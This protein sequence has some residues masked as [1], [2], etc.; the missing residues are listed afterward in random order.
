MSGHITPPEHDDISRRHFGVLTALGALAAAGLSAG[1]SPAR[2]P[3][4][5]TAVGSSGQAA[6]TL[7]AAVPNRIYRITEREPYRATLTP[8]N[9]FRAFWL[10]TVANIDW[11]SRPGLTVAQQ[12]SELRGWL[13]LARSMRFNTVLL[14]VRP[15]ADTFWPSSIGEPWSKYLTGVQGRHPGYDPLA[16]AVR[17]AHARNLHLH[18]WFNPF[19]VSMD[20]DLNN[21][22][23]SHPARLHPSWSF[24]Y[25]G[26]RY[27][28]PGIP[29]VRRFIIRVIAEVVAKYD[30]DGV[31][32]DD[33]FYPYPVAGQS[34]PDGAA[35]RSFR[36][37]G[38]SR[39]HF[40]RRSVNAFV[41]DLSSRIFT[42]KRRMLF[43][44]SPFGI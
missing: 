15:A 31:H 16:F 29:A 6:V 25:G 42:T 10:S 18:V 27:Y 35:Y 24:A 19:R 1:L 14:Q 5:V 34:I 28:N 12:Q 38:E 36:T 11:P 8:K 13:N 9:E 2:L 3:P 17:E 40:R 33:Y 32:L 20:T 43:G 23:P 22:V 41:R 30:V 39:A 4:A 7:A 26:R 44:I 21:L 37:L